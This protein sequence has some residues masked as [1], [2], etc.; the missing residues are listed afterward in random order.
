MMIDSEAFLFSVTDEEV[1]SPSGEF[2]IE[3]DPSFGPNF[4]DLFIRNNP[5]QH[6]RNFD[7]LGNLYGKDLKA[8]RGDLCCRGSTVG[9]EESQ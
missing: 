4:L 1:Y 6:D 5:N 3:H 9:P 2:Q 8:K 7:F